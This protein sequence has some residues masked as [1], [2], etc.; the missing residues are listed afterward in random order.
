MLPFIAALGQ[1]GGII[2]DKIVLTRHR[3]EVRVFIPV[4]FLFLF[5]LTT[6]LF[7]WLGWISDEFLTLKYQLLFWLMIL[8][9]IVW[10][11]FYY[12]GA[13]A[14]KVQEFE[15]IIM[16]QP[17]VTVFLASIFLTNERSWPIIIAATIA[18]LTLILSRL[19]K[20][21]LQF[22]REMWGLILAVF[23][24][25]LELIVIDLLLK[26]FS[27]VAIYCLRTGF[28]A[29]FFYLYYRP[30]LKMISRLNYG[31]ILLSAFLGV[32]QMVAKFYGFS[33]FGVIYTSLILT[34]APVLVYIFSIFWLH[35][36]LRARTILAALV[37]L[38]CIIYATIVSH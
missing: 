4:L 34:I 36:K 13:K 15:L 23:L 2:L 12:R 26:I 10:N 33:E 1:A 30:R 20:E 31:L 6:L 27:P 18:G 37:I 16:A 32:V 3:V 22:S 35:E 9:A 8:L 17:L 19:R 21:H 7:P 25:S 29:L 28:L 11:I 5:L 14:E 38:I 24:M